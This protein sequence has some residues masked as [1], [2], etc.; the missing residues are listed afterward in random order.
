MPRRKLYDAFAG[1][2]WEE[3]VRKGEDELLSLLEQIVEKSRESMFRGCLPTLIFGGYNP[4]AERAA[5]IVGSLVEKVAARE[6]YRCYLRCHISARSLSE[7]KR[8]LA[9]VRRHCTIV[10]L[11]LASRETTAFACRDRRVDIVTVVPGVTRAI[12]R[13]DILYAAERG[14]IFEL[15]LSHLLEGEKM[16]IAR[17]LSSVKLIVHKLTQKSLPLVLSSGPRLPYAPPS[18]RVL[19]SFAKEV[20]EVP[21]EMAARSMGP[22]L[23]ALIKQNREKI[24]GLRPFEGVVIEG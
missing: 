2:L 6:N 17:R 10:S 7:I 13:G 12:P 23:E 20:L 22:L 5:A 14:K 21:V 16:E 8:L 9:R 24:S 18:Y 1:G 11:E 15:T 4:R 19:L 3:D